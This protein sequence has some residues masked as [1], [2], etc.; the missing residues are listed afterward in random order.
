MILDIV[1]LALIASPTALAEAQGK[2]L[3]GF[4]HTPK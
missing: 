1:M 3:A 4:I 2:A